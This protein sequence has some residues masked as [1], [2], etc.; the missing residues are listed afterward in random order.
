MDILLVR[1]LR[2]GFTEL[3]FTESENNSAITVT[4]I[5]E[6]ENIATY[7]LM[8]SP[9]TY[10]QF[11]T[12]AVLPDGLIGNLPDAAECKAAKALINITAFVY[13]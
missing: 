13:S 10:A 2:Y 1:G 5:K 12:T 11:E 3:D 9:L 7:F 8:V 6:D 4:I